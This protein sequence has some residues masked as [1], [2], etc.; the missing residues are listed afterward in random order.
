MDEFGGALAD[1]LNAEHPRR[2]ALAEQRQET[3]GLARDVGARHFAEI[4]PADDQ[5][6]FL[7]RGLALR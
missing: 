2:A 7:R 3:R 5:V 1:H 6:D 4:G